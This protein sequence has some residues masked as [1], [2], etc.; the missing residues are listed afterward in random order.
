MQRP[1]GETALADA[2]DF[3]GVRF[4]GAFAAAKHCHRLIRP[5]SSMIF[6]SS[7]L[8]HSPSSGFAVGASISAA[9]EALTARS[10]LSWRRSGSMPSGRGSSVPKLGQASGS[11]PGGVLCV[12]QRALACGA[13]RMSRRCAE[14]YLFLMRSEFITGQLVVVDGGMLVA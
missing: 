6:T 14:A 12:A 10:R 4:W 13:H 11:R 5:G 1:I 7:T 8:P 3:F 9:V 2:R